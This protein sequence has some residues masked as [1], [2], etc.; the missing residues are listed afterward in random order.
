MTVFAIGSSRCQALGHPLTAL[1]GVAHP[2]GLEPATIIETAQ[3]LE[4]CRRAD[5]R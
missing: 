3:W 2:C 4:P 1:A 5:E